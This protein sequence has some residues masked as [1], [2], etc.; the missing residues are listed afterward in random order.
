M[1]GSPKYL[2]LQSLFGRPPRSVNVLPPSEEK[3]TPVSSSLYITAGPHPPSRKPVASFHA[4]TT[5]GPLAAIDSSDWP[6]ALVPPEVM[7]SLVLATSTF[8]VD[9]EV[10]PAEV[11]VDADEVLPDNE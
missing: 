1:L 3:P 5:Y 2:E 11:V 9:P 6:Y 8:F 10:E 4:S 7:S